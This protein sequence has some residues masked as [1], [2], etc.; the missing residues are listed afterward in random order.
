MIHEATYAHMLFVSER[1]TS[2]HPTHSGEGPILQDEMFPRALGGTVDMPSTPAVVPAAHASAD[3]ERGESTLKEILQYASIPL[4]VYEVH[5]EGNAP[6]EGG[7]VDGRLRQRVG[8]NTDGGGGNA[9]RSYC[10]GDRNPTCV[11]PGQ[12]AHGGQSLGRRGLVR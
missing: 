3:S 9:W 12:Q 11:N 2:A 4:S 7:I 5:H 1:F 8:A 10:H 6:T